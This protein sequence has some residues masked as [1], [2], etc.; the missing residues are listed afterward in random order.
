MGEQGLQEEAEHAPLR[1]TSVVD[2]RSGD[3]VSYLPHLGV[4]C[5]QGGVETQGLS[6]MMSLEGTMV[7]NAEL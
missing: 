4:A 2:L 5:P 1:S 7:L 6:L 3:V